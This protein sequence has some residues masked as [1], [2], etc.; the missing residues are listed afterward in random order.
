MLQYIYIRTL[1][2]REDIGT[3]GQM[4]KPKRKKEK[5]LVISF[6]NVSLYKASNFHST[7]LF[8]NSENHRLI[9]TAINQPT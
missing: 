5:I 7:F 4:S 9:T 6:E 3:F 2:A 1:K 8:T